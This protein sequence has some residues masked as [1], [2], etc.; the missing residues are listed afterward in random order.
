MELFGSD[1]GEGVVEGAFEAE[2]VDPFDVGEDGLGVGGVGAVGVASGRVLTTGLFFDDVAVSGHG[3]QQWE[4]VEMA[5][6]VFEYGNATFGV[7]ELV[8]TDVELDM[9]TRDFHQCLHSVGDAGGG[10]DVERLFAST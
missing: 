2:E 8:V 6:V 4:G 9:A 3:M 5:E 10:I 7:G 1:G